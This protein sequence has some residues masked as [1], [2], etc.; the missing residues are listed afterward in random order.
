MSV[1]DS[2]CGRRRIGRNLLKKKGSTQLE[3][4]NCSGSGKSGY[5]EFKP[6]EKENNY[7]LRKWMRIEKKAFSLPIFAKVGHSANYLLKDRRFSYEKRPGLPPA[8]V[9]SMR[10]NRKDLLCRI[11]PTAA[12]NKCVDEPPSTTA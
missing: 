3:E 9:I 7:E 5:V 1:D 8:F 2:N 12:V 4:W 10:K 11:H 6:R